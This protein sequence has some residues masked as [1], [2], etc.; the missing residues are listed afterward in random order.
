MAFSGSNNQ[1]IDLST[2]YRQ[3][4][5]DNNMHRRNEQRN[6]ADLHGDQPGPSTATP[7]QT[8]HIDPERLLAELDI[9]RDDR[10]D[11]GENSK[12]L[13]KRRLLFQWIL[14]LTQDLERL[15]G[16]LD[17]RETAFITEHKRSKETISLCK[18]EISSLKDKLQSQKEQ[19]DAIR[20]VNHQEKERMAASLEIERQKMSEQEDEI[21]QLQIKVSELEHRRVEE[22]LNLRKENVHLSHSLQ[23]ATEDLQT[24]KA[25]ILQSKEDWREKYN[26]LQEDV[27]VKMAN[28]EKIWYRAFKELKEKLK[29]SL[30]E[31]EQL[32]YK[33]QKE[34]KAEISSLKERLE[35][36]KEQLEAIQK[37]NHQ[38]IEKMAASL[39]AEKQ[40]VSEKNYEIILLKMRVRQFKLQK[41][42][43]LQNLNK[44]IDHQ[45][46]SLQEA[47][48][49]QQNH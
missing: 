8:F 42:E 20:E 28:K 36:Q 30:K 4:T 24:N 38:E 49:S 46:H 44:D 31:Q 35:S 13:E 16:L 34:A 22:L 3:S 18:E 37:L 45:S 48:E 1:S 39:E 41:D 25:E 7:T 32:K 17:L 5:S 43:E 47:T 6:Q 14:H 29:K 27:R 2:V 33:Q 11:G 26:A 23:E 21:I 9:F 12:G 40:K 15:K 10:P 19:L